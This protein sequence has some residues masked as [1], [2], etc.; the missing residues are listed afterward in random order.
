MGL[1]GEPEGAQQVRQFW[2]QQRQ[3][4]RQGVLE[5]LP[6]FSRDSRVVAL[7]DGSGGG[8]GVR[9]NGENNLGAETRYGRN[10]PVT[11]YATVGIAP[12]TLVGF[13]AKRLQVTVQNLHDANALYIRLGGVPTA[14]QDLMLPPGATYSLPPGVAFEG[15]IGAVASGA[16]TGVVVVEYKVQQ[17]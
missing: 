7:E 12:A 5:A 3:A 9:V 8:Y 15:S 17:E 1:Q 14:G 6:A 16:N 11:T 13:T 4:E 2:L 10:D